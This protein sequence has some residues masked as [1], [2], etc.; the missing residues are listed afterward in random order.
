[1]E[2]QKSWRMRKADH[3]P[4]SGGV[5]SLKSTGKTR[6]FFKS[7]VCPPNFLTLGLPPFCAVRMSYVHV[8][9]DL[10][11]DNMRFDIN[12]ILGG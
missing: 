8:P 10:S 6:S 12:V 9:Y 11:H 4:S 2:D 1:M 5:E 7:A 3:P